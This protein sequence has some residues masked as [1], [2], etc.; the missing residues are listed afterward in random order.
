M[1]A[2]DYYLCDRCSAKTFYDANTHYELD[3]SGRGYHFVG[4]GDM[5]AI[6]KRCAETHEVVLVTL[7]EIG[8]GDD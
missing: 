8:A 6:C 7:T 3:D 5:K 4:V 1:A 2:G